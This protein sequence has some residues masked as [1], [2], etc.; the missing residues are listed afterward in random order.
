M[1]F[2]AAAAAAQPAVSRIKSTLFVPDPLPPLA[3]ETY[4]QFPA[5]PGVVGERVSYA[6]GYG[7][8][9]PAIVYRPAHPGAAKAPGIVVVNGHGGDKYSWYAL[10]TGCLLYTSLKL[11]DESPSGRQ[12]A[13]GR[14]A[15]RMPTKGVTCRP[16]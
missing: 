11:I 10:Y 14:P 5:A 16:P 1:I 3:T 7:L 12:A 9:V 6:T 8:R 4:G 2:L 15:P 13:G